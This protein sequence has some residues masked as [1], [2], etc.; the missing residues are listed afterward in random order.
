V[1]RRR[2]DAAKSVGQI[3]SFVT[4][5]VIENPNLVDAQNLTN[6]RRDLESVIQ[7]S[8]H[9]QKEA[10]RMHKKHKEKP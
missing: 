8:G 10:A 7:L 5:P 4:N 9:L 6:A 2:E 3:R 1:T